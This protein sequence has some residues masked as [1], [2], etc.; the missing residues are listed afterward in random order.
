MT[1]PSAV[2]SR[3]FHFSSSWYGL[4]WR[5]SMFTCHLA[6]TQWRTLMWSLKVCMGI[7]P[8]KKWTEMSFLWPTAFILGFPKQTQLDTR[9]S[10]SADSGCSAKTVF[11]SLTSS[12][13]SAISSTMNKMSARCSGTISG[14]C[15]VL[16]WRIWQSRFKTFRLII[17]TKLRRSSTITATK[18]RTT[19]SLSSTLVLTS[20]QWLVGPIAKQ[21]LKVRQSSINSTSKP[22]FRRCSGTPKTSLETTKGWTLSSRQTMCS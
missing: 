9:I 5:R 22:R 10:T 3:W 20:P 1:R 2:S 7:G 14:V 13:S 11:Q 6:S 12:L 21:R 16:T 15:I 17:A 4:L 19:F 8:F 18:P